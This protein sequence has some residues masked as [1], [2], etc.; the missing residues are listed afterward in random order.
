[1]AT[2]KKDP[3]LVILQLSGGNDYLNTVVPHSNPL[4]ADNRTNLQVPED[5]VLKLNDDIGFNPTM[6]PIKEMWD[7]GNVAIL[8][9]VGWEGSNRSHFRC[10]DIWHT[11]D[12]EKI[13]EEGW[14]G[15]AIRQLDPKGENP[16]TAVNVGQG[17]PRALVAPGASVAS[18]ADLNSYGMLT[19]IEEKD[20]RD[21]M[22]ERF[23][24]MYA[25]ALGQGPVMDYLG[26][27]GLDALRGADMLKTAPQMYDSQVEHSNSPLAKK[28]KDIS[29]IH[30]AGL[31]TRILYTEHGGY[32][33]HASQATAHPKLWNEVSTSIQD[34]WDDLREND[35]DE[36]VVMFIFTEFGRRVKENG[37]GTD[38]GAG[39]V[40]FAIGP[41]V[42]GGIYGEYPSIKP[43]ELVE[44]DLK[45]SMDFRQAYTTLLEDHMKLDPISIVDG[46]YEK[47]QFI[48]TNGT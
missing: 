43:E 30:Q 38:H 29:M 33:T 15:R 27:T 19:A 4:Y 17:L 34:F 31:G 18:V 20:K 35:A 7:R 2:A 14:L 47:P 9:G 44:G 39:G 11:I 21:R 28:M 3:V 23:K 8:H 26:Q 24:K 5:D 13:G 10:M 6:A 45:P 1:M 46:T 16:V 40:A 25:P 42:S 22:L 41:R 32:D 36:N 12:T 37:T 48:K